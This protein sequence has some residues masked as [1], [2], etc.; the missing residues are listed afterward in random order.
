MLDRSE[1]G[2][3]AISSAV[4]LVGIAVITHDYF[5]ENMPL[6]A[7]PYA[8]IVLAAALISPLFGW[9]GGHYYASR[10]E[11]AWDEAGAKRERLPRAC[12]H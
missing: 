7:N 8:P 12:T 3:Y 5:N 2:L 6:A 1:L 11:S 4:M 9:L 10:F